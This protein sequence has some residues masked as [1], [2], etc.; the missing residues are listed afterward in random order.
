M[1]KILDRY[2]IKELLD[3][4]LFGLGSFTAI[5]S[6]SMIMFELVRAV[7]LQGMPIFIAL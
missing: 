2:I 5:L 7:V 3:P 1:I 4:F 6:A